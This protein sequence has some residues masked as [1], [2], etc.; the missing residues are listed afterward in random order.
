MNLTI[1]A[2]DICCVR[3]H[4]VSYYRTFV[5]TEIVML[6]SIKVSVSNKNRILRRLKVTLKNQRC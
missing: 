3:V 5:G 4:D 2:H 6:I 1:P